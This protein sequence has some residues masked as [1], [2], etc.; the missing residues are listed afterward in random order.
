MV[1][2][3]TLGRRGL[4]EGKPTARA[5]GNSVVTSDVRGAPAARPG[6]TD[7][8]NTSPYGGVEKI[9]PAS[10]LGEITYARPF[11][12]GRLIERD[13]HIIARR[14]TTVTSAAEQEPASGIPNPEADGPPR[15]AYTMVDRTV[16]WQIGT[17]S[18]RFLDNNAPHAATNAGRRRFPLGNQGSSPYEPVYGGTPGLYRP[19]GARG[20]VIGPAPAVVSL[21]GGPNKPNVLLEA[22]S[23]EDGP[24]SVYGGAPHGLHSPTVE[25]TKVTRGRYASTK[26][27]T[28][29]R[30]NRPANSKI[31]GQSYSQTVVPQDGVGG[32]PLPRL[33]AEHQ[34]GV[35][36]RFLGR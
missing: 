19:Y 12:H 6:N 16:S 13:R 34:A 28:P 7:G 33:P 4:P 23:P 2:I 1:A 26:Q 9:T 27:Q 20:F 10:Q 36:R 5:S 11:Q 25:P 15:P 35:N 32:G 18:T 14:G 30:Q 21:P 3:P 22:G 31:A 29:P 17:D 8:L 24:Q